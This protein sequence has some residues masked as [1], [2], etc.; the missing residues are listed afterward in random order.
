[1]IFK[2]R[3][4]E[5]VFAADSPEVLTLTKMGFTFRPMKSLF[6]PKTPSAVKERVMLDKD[7]SEI[8]LDT[9]EE[10]IAFQRVCG[11]EIMLLDETITIYNGYME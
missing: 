9:V 5:Y 4:A 8:N 6:E 3:S 7:V 11:H 2:L 10:F 1:M